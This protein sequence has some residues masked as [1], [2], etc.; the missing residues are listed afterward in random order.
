LE[1]GER[2]GRGKGTGREGEQEGKGK[3]KEWKGEALPPPMAGLD[4]PLS[5]SGKEQSARSYEFQIQ[6]I[7]IILYFHNDIYR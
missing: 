7:T 3:E 1:I 5:V 2:D 4:P 6:L